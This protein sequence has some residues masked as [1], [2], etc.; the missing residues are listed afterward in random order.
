MRLLLL[1]QPT[2]PPTYPHPQALRVIRVT[3]SMQQTQQAQV[4][5]TEKLHQEPDMA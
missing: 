3:G 2:H 4:L 1:Y 5:I